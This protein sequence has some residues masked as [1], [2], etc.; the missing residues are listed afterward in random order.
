MEMH[1]EKTLG[2]LVA[3]IR[4][5]APLSDDL[6]GAL[7]ECSSKPSWLAHGF[8]RERAGLP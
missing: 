4:A 5:V 1:F 2:R 6:F 3:A 7:K 8:F